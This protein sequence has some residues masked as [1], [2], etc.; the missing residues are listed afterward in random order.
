MA[1][2]PG[3]QTLRF[4]SALITP[5]PGPKLSSQDLFVY[6]VPRLQNCNKRDS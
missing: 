6:L 5:M 4:E 2:T 1:L 3:I